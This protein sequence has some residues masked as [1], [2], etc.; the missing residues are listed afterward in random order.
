MNNNLVLENAQLQMEKD[1]ENAEKKFLLTKA[2]LA[3]KNLRKEIN[4]GDL[5]NNFINNNITGGNESN[6]NDL[7]NPGNIL[8]T[9]SILNKL[10]YNGFYS[11]VIIGV[12]LVLFVFILFRIFNK[13]NN[14]ENM[15]K[16]NH[17]LSNNRERFG[18]YNLPIR[19]HNMTDYGKFY[20]YPINNLNV[21]DYR[22][23]KY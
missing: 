11:G 12:L 7:N 14:M 2:E 17:N 21:L 19:Y 4:G 10:N 1:I 8:N 5:Y 3:C 18:T 13:V 15:I 22:I 23:K 16:N 20:K 9:N 6:I